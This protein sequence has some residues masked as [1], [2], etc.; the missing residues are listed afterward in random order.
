MTLQRVSSITHTTGEDVGIFR[1]LTLLGVQRQRADYLVWTQCN[2]G[3][4]MVILGSTL[5]APLGSGTRGYEQGTRSG[6]HLASG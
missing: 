5:R 4:E 2:L 1:K 3:R 6:R